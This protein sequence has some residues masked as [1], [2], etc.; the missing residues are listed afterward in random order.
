MELGCEPQVGPVSPTLWPHSGARVPLGLEMTDNSQWDP[1][2][3]LNGHGDCLGPQGSGK[4]LG[5]LAESGSSLR[6]AG[7]RWGAV[8]K[9]PT[10]RVAW[11]GDRRTAGE[12][13]ARDFRQIPGM[14]G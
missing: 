14:W 8:E 6:S 1:L 3:R 2:L 4:G 10:V 9:A 12:W 7:G 11:V 5:K 13:M